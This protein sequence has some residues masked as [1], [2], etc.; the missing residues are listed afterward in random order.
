[1]KPRTLSGPKPNNI[2]Q[3]MNAAAFMLWLKQRRK[4]LTIR[5]KG[6]KLTILEIITQISEEWNALSDEDKQRWLDEEQHM[7]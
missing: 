1:M 5:K 3:P 6:R 7:V 4:E 2:K